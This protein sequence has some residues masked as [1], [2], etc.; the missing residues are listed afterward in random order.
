[1]PCSRHGVAPQVAYDERAARL[2]AE[3]DLVEER[4]LQRVE[5]DAVAEPAQL[6]GACPLR[7]WRRTRDAV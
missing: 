2:V 4:P 3:D 5:R 1:M 6:D 7:G